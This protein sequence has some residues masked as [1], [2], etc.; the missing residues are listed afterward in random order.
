MNP[1]K[2]KGKRYEYEIR[3]YFKSIGYTDC[4]I[5]SSEST[6][7]DNMG[8]DLMNLP[9]VVQCKN[10]YKSGLKYLEI[11][12]NIVKKTKGT[13]YEGQMVFIFHKNKRRT[14]VTMSFK[15]YYILVDKKSVNI[16]QSMK[17]FC[18]NYDGT[19]TMD[20]ETF[21]VQ[22]EKWKDILVEESSY[23]VLK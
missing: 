1:N 13:K 2:S 18:K 6:N 3:D 8:I 5:S 23:P 12:N 4:I 20:Y 11:L 14:E 7:A 19:L 17:Y 16:T 22:I 21:K 9:F 15:D 10:G